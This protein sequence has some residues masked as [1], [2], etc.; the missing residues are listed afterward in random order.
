MA[1]SRWRCEW[2]AVFFSHLAASWKV[3]YTP[4]RERPAPKTSLSTA[5]PGADQTKTGGWAPRWRHERRNALAHDEQWAPPAPG[6]PLFGR[7]PREPMEDPQ[8]FP[9][10]FGDLLK[11]YRTQQGVTQRQLADK[12]GLHQNTVG[13]WER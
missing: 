5:Q 8:P 13:A 1:D 3:V 9:A 6:A 4:L 7:R 11:A 10:S 2:L 12:L